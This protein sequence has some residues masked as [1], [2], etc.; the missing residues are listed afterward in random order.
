MNDELNFRSQPVHVS[1]CKGFP[2]MRIE[3]N[4]PVAQKRYAR[5]Y[6][7]MMSKNDRQIFRDKF[8]KRSL[9]IALMLN[10]TYLISSY[11]AIIIYLYSIS[12][13]PLFM[14]VL[15]GITLVL[16]VVRQMRALENVVHFGSHNNFTKHKKTND[17]IVNLLASWPMLSSVE[18]YRNFHDLHHRFFGSDRDPCR[19]R[20]QRMG[21][22]VNTSGRFGLVK[23]VIS[24]LPTYIR[25]Y[26]V[27]VGSSYRQ[28]LCFVI[29]HLSAFLF[30]A[31]FFPIQIA[32]LT[33][34]CWLALMLCILPIIRS[35][36][37]YSEHDYEIGKTEYNT[38]YN[39]LSLLDH[40]LCHPAGD[41]Y[42]ILHHLYPAVPWWKQ[43]AP[44]RF[45]MRRDAI[46]PIALHRP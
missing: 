29:W 6:K 33:E 36:A 28:I 20:F 16:F 3:H 42:H 19:V 37:E 38:T 1:W 34:G 21:G 35:I 40:L 2:L 45:L 26:Y 46:Y 14:Q 43:A 11:S 9:L 25:D 41:A 27:D 13:L 22:A 15:V 23:A 39:N 18:T 32:L 31:L 8:I 30:L 24:W 12:K 4:D 10:L 44:H 7:S 5:G 17:S